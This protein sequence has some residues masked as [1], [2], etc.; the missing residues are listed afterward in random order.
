MTWFLALLIGGVLGWMFS[1]S[2]YETRIQDI[3]QECNTLRTS[4]SELAQRNL[5]LSDEVSRH[6]DEIL[7]L[8]ESYRREGNALK[9]KMTHLKIRLERQERQFAD[10][11]EELKKF[12]T[13]K[14]DA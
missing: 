8:E 10:K 1:M 3:T 4:A 7:C 14:I 2:Q 11:I 9:L 12:H 6:I 13:L 5:R